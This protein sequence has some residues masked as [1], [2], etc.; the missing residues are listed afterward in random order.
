[1]SDSP[2]TF[3]DLYDAFQTE[4]CT[5]LRIL[6]DS[7][8]MSGSRAVTVASGAFCMGFLSAIRMFIEAPDDQVSSVMIRSTE[9]CSDI[10]SG[11]RSASEQELID[12]LT[13]SMT[14][15]DVC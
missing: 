9:E 14:K 1:M 4:Q 3:R 11:L 7:V 13:A 2:V 12:R 10:L 6:H 15:R 5:P 8:K